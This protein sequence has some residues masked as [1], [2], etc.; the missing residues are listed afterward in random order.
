MENPL[1]IKEIYYRDHY[2]VKQKL[3]NIVI[4]RNVKNKKLL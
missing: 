1:P 3:F 2:F 4:N